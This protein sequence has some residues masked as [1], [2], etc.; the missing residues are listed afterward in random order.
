[1]RKLVFTALGAA[2]LVPAALTPQQAS[3]AEEVSA[4][5]D[6]PTVCSFAPTGTTG[7]VDISTTA[8]TRTFDIECNSFYQL[9]ILLSSGGLLPGPTTTASPGATGTL[10]LTHQGP[11][12]TGFAP[13]ADSAIDVITS[14]GPISLSTPGQA[15]AGTNTVTV[16]FGVASFVGGGAFAGSYDGS[17]TL[18]FVP[19]L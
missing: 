18:T 14:A 17:V 3:A 10:E 13:T 15:T 1:M 4:A 11:V 12:P 19:T 16:G 5:I 8:A 2:A 6:V 7:A 9:D